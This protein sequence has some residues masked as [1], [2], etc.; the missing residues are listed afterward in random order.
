MKYHTDDN[1]IIDMHEVTPAEELMDNFPITSATSQLV[2][3]TRQAASDIISGRSDKLLAIIGPCSIH[4][5]ESALEYAK[6]LAVVKR[7]VEDDMCIL[8]RVYFEKPRTTIGW[9]GLINDPNLDGSFEIDKGLRIARKLL[10]DITDLGIAVGTEYLDPITPQY[11]GDLVSWSAIGA[12]TTES[13]IH[14]QLAS[15]LSCPVGFKNSTNGDCQIAA[16]AVKSARYP[17]GFLSVTKSSK[18]AIFF[19]SGNE[20][21]HIILRGGGG[22]TNYDRLSIQIASGMLQK[23]N[24]PNLLMVDMSHANSEKQHEKQLNVCKKLCNQIAGGENRI[25]GTMIESHLVPGNQSIGDGRHLTY[26]QSITDACL[27]WEDT[28]RCIHELSD[29]V[30]AR[31]TSSHPP[32]IKATASV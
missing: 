5:I 4:D 30:Q 17:H 18:S 2:F 1:R 27:G 6:R 16:D 25:M 32:K 10:V 23:H 19:T 20:D 3:S 8:M 13:Q 7:E 26:G 11:V 14:R 9:K 15:G 31:R 24:L 22:K 12:R 21:C 29:A 28:V